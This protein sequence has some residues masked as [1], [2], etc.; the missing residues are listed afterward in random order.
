MALV[1]LLIAT[2]IFSTIYWGLRLGGILGA[3]TGIIVAGLVSLFNYF[4]VKNLGERCWLWRKHLID[5]KLPVIWP[6]RIFLFLNFALCLWI[7]ISS[8]IGSF[9]TSLLFNLC[10]R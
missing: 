6:R 3:L 4:S 2:P 1:V 7:V 8:L 9:V 5:N 10:F